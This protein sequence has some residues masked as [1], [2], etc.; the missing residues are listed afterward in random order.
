MGQKTGCPSCSGIFE[1]RDL[2]PLQ[3][4]LDHRCIQFDSVLHSTRFFHRNPLSLPTNTAPVRYLEDE[5]PFEGTPCQLPCV[6]EGKSS[7]RGSEAIGPKVHPVRFPRASPGGSQRSSRQTSNGGSRGGR[8]LLWLSFGRSWCPF[9][10][11]F[12][13]DN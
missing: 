13:K 8:S 3:V 2:C 9:F 12:Q 7:G 6:R 10:G 11:R 4:N 1:R 5:F